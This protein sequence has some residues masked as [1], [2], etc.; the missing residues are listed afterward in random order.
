LRLGITDP[1]IRKALEIIHHELY[2]RYA[3][4]QLPRRAYYYYDP[5]KDENP[6]RDTFKIYKNLIERP[7]YIITP[8]DNYDKRVYPL[9]LQSLAYSKIYAVSIVYL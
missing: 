3:C 6:P 9:F 4:E 8:A 7:A 5:D 1:F 2:Y